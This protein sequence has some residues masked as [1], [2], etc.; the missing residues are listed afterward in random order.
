MAGS[1]QLEE[2]CRRHIRHLIEKQGW[3]LLSEDEWLAHVLKHYPDR[4]DLQRGADAESKL[5]TLC[6]AIYCEYGLYPACKGVRGDGIRK[7]GF[8]EVAYYLYDRMVY[9]L[10]PQ[11][12]EDAAHDA[13]IELHRTIDKVTTPAAF[14]SFARQK[15]RDAVRKIVRNEERMLSLE[16]PNE[17]EGD[18]TSGPFDP[19]TADVIQAERAQKVLDAMNRIVEENPRSKEQIKAFVLRH[20][21]GIPIEQIAV[22]LKKSPDQIY[23]L[24]SRA[25][26]RLR[27]DPELRQLL[28]D[29]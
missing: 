27:D 6:I 25:K 14:L 28:D 19:V 17:D 11:N 29:L 4:I 15:L 10:P 22:R 9:F 23:V 1:N 16:L 26:K 21:Y 18:V 13:I 20:L 24:I 5:Q 7:Q 8:E 2:A 12:A 3:T